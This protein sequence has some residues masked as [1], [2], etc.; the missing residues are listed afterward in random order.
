MAGLGLFSVEA[1]KSLGDGKG[2]EK[3]EQPQLLS[4]SQSF[5]NKPA[6]SA[7]IQD[8]PFLSLGGFCALEGPPGMQNCVCSLHNVLSSMVRF[9]PK[10]VANYCIYC[11]SGDAMPLHPVTIC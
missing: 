2:E 1:Q 4:L 5:L 9:I 7:G 8:F 11:I 6:F 3:L 10:E